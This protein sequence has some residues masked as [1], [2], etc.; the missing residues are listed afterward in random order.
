MSKKRKE[1]ISFAFILLQ[2]QAQRFAEEQSADNWT[3]AVKMSYLKEVFCTFWA[4]GICLYNSLSWLD[5]QT[6]EYCYNEYIF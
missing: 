1:N 6:H 3:M 5:K 4:P 2:I